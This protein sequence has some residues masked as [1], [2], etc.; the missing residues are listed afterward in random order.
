MKP[1]ISGGD[2]SCKHKQVKDSG[3][4]SCTFFQECLKCGALLTFYTGH[5]HF[6]AAAEA[7]AEPPSDY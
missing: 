3:R 7:A 5:D 4:G 1:E 6:L 2:P